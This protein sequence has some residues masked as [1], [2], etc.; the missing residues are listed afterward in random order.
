M[1]KLI[2]I[3]LIFISFSIFAQDVQFSNIFANPTYMNPHLKNQPNT[4]PPIALEIQAIFKI[5]DIIE[6]TDA[7]GEKLYFFIH[8]QIVTNNLNEE[9]YINY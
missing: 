7:L 4:L 2:N 5:P 9:M 3:F 8:S 1:K 6:R